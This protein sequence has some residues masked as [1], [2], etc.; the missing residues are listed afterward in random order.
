MPEGTANST[1]PIVAFIGLGM[2]GLPMANRLV[3]AG[4]AT[5]GFDLSE[6]ARAALVEKG[7]TAF[8]DIR[9]AVK[10]ASVV[11]TMLPDGKIVRD[12]LLGANGLY[13]VLPKGTLIIDMSSSAPLGTKALGD[14][15]AAHG[16]RL[17]DGPVS[18]GVRRAV[19]GSLAIMAGGDADDVAEAR[20]VLEAM[21][22]SI[23]ATGPLG[24]GHAM[25]ALNNYVSA[26]GLLAACEALAV[27][28]K[29]GIAGETVVDVLNASTGK[30]NSTEVKL[31]PFVLSGSFA[32]G[33]SMALMV[34]DLRTAAELGAQLGLADSLLDTTS[35][36]WA[37]ALEGLSQQA[38]HTEIFRAVRTDGDAL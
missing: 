5:R 33:F 21:G 15:L 34:K 20:P 7:G 16:L 29:F 17:V 4:F 35:E 22:R 28:Q 32:S 6:A 2:M 38:D 26:A 14:D 12:V 25:K 23:F 37:A 24:S 1:R 11:I 18:G 8:P 10:G 9:E 36:R 3:Q 31:K 30:N 19:D 13:Q 27:A